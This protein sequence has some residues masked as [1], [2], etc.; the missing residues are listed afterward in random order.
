MSRRGNDEYERDMGDRRSLARRERQRERDSREPMD[1]QLRRV[2]DRDP[3]RLE[4]IRDSRSDRTFDSRSDRTFD[5]RS[6]RTFESRS[7]RTFDNRLDRRSDRDPASRPPYSYSS[8]DKIDRDNLHSRGYV[9]DSQD[10][11]RTPIGL[12]PERREEA[13]SRC[14]NNYFL[15]GEG[16]NR[17]VIQNDICRYLGVDATVRPYTHPDG[18]QGYLIE[19]YRA[20]TTVSN[21]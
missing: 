17:E 11:H 8:T 21:V 3:D 13:S 15:P 6:D 5:S 12:K 19:A 16:I 4:Y 20:L 10:R 18:R 9:D 1:P 14:Q 2:E 7:D